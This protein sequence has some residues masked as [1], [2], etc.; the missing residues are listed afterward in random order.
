MRTVLNVG[1]DVTL[2]CAT[3][4][5]PK[6]YANNNGDNFYKKVMINNDYRYINNWNND[7]ND[8]NNINIITFI[9]RLFIIYTANK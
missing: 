3:D 1:D 6:I 2:D 5:N 4:W 8:N 7:D 9:K